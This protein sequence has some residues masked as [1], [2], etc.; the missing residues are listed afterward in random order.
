[1][2]TFE[3]PWGNY[4]LAELAETHAPESISWFPQTIGWQCVFVVLLVMV[5]HKTYRAVKRYQYNIY[6]REALHWLNN[7][8]DYNADAPEVIFRQ[9]P[10]LLRS[11]ALH[12]YQREE[13]T[14][15]SHARWESWLDEQCAQTHF[16]GENTQRLYQLA[17]APNYHLDSQQMRFLLSDIVTWIKDHRGSYA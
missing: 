6:R 3:L 13:V 16:S 8:P 5:V 7:L 17:Y 11:V 4:L 9:L 2:N 12:A 15:L 14:L 1:M 10:S